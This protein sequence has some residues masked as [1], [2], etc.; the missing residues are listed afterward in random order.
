MTNAKLGIDLISNNHALG[1]CKMTRCLRAPG[2]FERMGSSWVM[3]WPLAGLA[4][5]ILCV[6]I[7]VR[8]LGGLQHNTTIGPVCLTAPTHTH[9]L[10]GRQWSLTMVTL[11]LVRLIHPVEGFIVHYHLMRFPA[12]AG[13]HQRV[14]YMYLV[15]NTGWVVLQP[16]TPSCCP[17]LHHCVFRDGCS[18]RLCGCVCLRSCIAV[19]PEQGPWV[20]LASN[21]GSCLSLA[22]TGLVVSTRLYGGGCHMTRAHCRYVSSTR[23]FRTV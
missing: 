6:P 2:S 4:A 14:L 12:V 10:T 19:R 9:A 7:R 22:W 15:L 3:S 16:P 20:Q 18:R 11:S 21:R 23:W 13:C 1:E 8:P 5:T 17:W